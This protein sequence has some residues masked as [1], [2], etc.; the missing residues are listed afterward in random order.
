MYKLGLTVLQQEI[1]R[2]LFVKAGMSLNQR[3]IAR[4]LG[5]SQPAV[6]KA[7]PQLEENGMIKVRQD[8]ESRRW[9]VELNRNNHKVMQLKRVD[10]LKQIY[11]NHFI[12]AS[13][14]NQLFLGD[15]AKMF[16]SF[17]QEVKRGKSPEAHGTSTK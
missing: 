4:T 2:L 6:M 8:K 10:N 9:S 3:G 12:N 13:S 5:V 7:L 17:Q 14:L 15:H 11:F 16:K 1:L